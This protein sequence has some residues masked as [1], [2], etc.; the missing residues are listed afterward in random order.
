MKHKKLLDR[1]D[2]INL[3]KDIQAGRTSIT[4]LSMPE[5]AVYYQKA[6][7]LFYVWEAGKELTEQELHAYMDTHRAKRVLLYVRQPGNE[8][9]EGEQD[10]L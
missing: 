3:L 5:Q 8:P 7:G 6:N 2:K 1:I 4:A 9:I 10:S